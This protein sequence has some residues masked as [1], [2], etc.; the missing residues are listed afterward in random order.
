MS[1]WKRV[2]SEMISLEGTKLSWKANFIIKPCFLKLYLKISIY[3][4]MVSKKEN[5]FI[6]RI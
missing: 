6:F 5:V 2:L 1:N 4:F 3:S